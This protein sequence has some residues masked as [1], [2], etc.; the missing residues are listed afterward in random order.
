MQNQQRAVRN[1]SLWQWRKQS[2][3]ATLSITDVL[4]VLV[5]H[6]IDDACVS[7]LRQLSC[8]RLVQQQAED[9]AQQRSTLQQ[10]SADNAAALAA[11]ERQAAAALQ[12]AE[13]EQ[14]LA[15]QEAQQA[16]ERQ[17]A[18]L[19]QQRV[20]AVLHARLAAQQQLEKERQQWQAERDA[21]VQKLAVQHA[22]AE[23][24]VR[25]V[26]ALLGW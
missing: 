9:L 8:C 10:L 6:A 21:L 15:M 14:R 13:R 16:W 4:V 20:E 24:Q 3:P 11:A 1:R 5:S 19:E 22:S 17:K 12:A 25:C 23:L 18:A 2:C 26:L 7:C